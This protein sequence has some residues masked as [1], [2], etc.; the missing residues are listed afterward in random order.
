MLECFVINCGNGW[1]CDGCFCLITED[2]DKSQKRP[3]LITK[4]VSENSLVH[5]IVHAINTQCLIVG[6][7]QLFTTVPNRQ[8]QI[9]GGPAGSEPSSVQ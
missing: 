7:V 3:K 4:K 1:L 2:L 9:F 6:N 5:H 8:W